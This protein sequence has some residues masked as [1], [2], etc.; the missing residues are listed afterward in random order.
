M[1]KNKA[2][3]EAAAQALRVEQMSLL[4]QIDGIVERIEVAPGE[5]TNPEQPLI[6]IVKNDPLEIELHLP[7]AAAGR[8]K[9]GDKMEVRYPDETAWK[10]A[11]VSYLSPVV[12]SK[13]GTREIRLQMPN[14]ELRET[15]LQIIAKVPDVAGGGAAET[16]A[17]VPAR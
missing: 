8:L 3:A 10:T 6:W 17:A 1:E 13:G 11:A 14:P 4:S 15:G 5:M 12:N 2:G 7:A 9:L 16:A